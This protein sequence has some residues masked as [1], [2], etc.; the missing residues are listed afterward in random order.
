[1]RL[2]TRLPTER[3]P[4]VEGVKFVSTPRNEGHLD[5]Q[6][7]TVSLELETDPALEKYPELKVACSSASRYGCL[8]DWGSSHSV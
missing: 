8:C 7:V 3:A 2:W 5:V 6:A 1:M 4:Y